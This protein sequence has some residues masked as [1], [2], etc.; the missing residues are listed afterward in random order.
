MAGGDQFAVQSG[1]RPVV[2]G[3]L[4]LNRR[5]INR[6]KRQRLAGD[7]VR[8]GLADKNILEPGHADDV[9]RVGLG[10]F[11]AL[12]PFKMENGGDFAG[13]LPAVPVQTGGGVAHFHLA[14]VNFAK[15][16]SAEVIGVI[17]VGGEHLEFRRRHGRG[18][19]EC[20]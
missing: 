4:H 14:A 8:D 19:A 12:Q 7:V 11:N 17:E 16:D 1:Q 13:G 2:D 3:E 9:A 20:V 18:A 10:D 15:G 5:R 6:H